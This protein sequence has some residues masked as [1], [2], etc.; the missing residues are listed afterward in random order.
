MDPEKANNEEIK[1]NIMY[2]NANSFNENNKNEI[3]LS[4]KSK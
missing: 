3:I 4:F 2:L 1:E